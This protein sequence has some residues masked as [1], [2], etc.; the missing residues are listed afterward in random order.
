MSTG[1]G[2]TLSLDGEDV[3]C[4]S[5]R[6]TQRAVEEA[7]GVTSCILD[8][9]VFCGQH[10]FDRLLEASDVRLK[11]ERSLISPLD[12]W[13]GAVFTNRSVAREEANARL[14]EYD[15]IE[16]EMIG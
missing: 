10:F 15:K 12:V 1:G 14:L 16:A 4:Q 13:R 9:T 8:R 11:E 5:I 6:Y 3:T 2:L 7:L